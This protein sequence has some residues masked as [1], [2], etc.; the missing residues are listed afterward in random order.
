MVRINSSRYGSITIEGVRYNHDVYILPSDQVED[1]KYGHTFTRDQV[2]HV[3]KGNPEVVFIGKGTS[4][5]A[6]L[7]PDAR[8]LLEKKG[9]RIIE[10]D[11][12]DMVDEFNEFAATKR[13]AAIVHVTC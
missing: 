10:A 7:S 2:E 3:L 13:V 5:M 4:G 6:S 11:T 9:V 1:R 12:P 8:A